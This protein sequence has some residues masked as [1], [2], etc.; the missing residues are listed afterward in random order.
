MLES[1][2]IEFKRELNKDFEKSVISFLNYPGGG[3]IYIGIADN[4]EVIGVS[5]A[6]DLQCE[7]ASRIR[8]NI[9]PITIGLFDIVLEKK[10]NKDIIRVIV[11]CGQMR[12]YYLKKYG[13]V[14]KGCFIRVGSTSQPMSEDVIDKAF[15]SRQHMSLQNTMSSRQS[16][17]H[18][19][20][21]LNYREKKF[22]ITDSFLKNLDLYQSDGKFNYLAY[23]LADDNGNSIKTAT[24]AGKDKSDVIETREYEYTCLLTSTQKVLDRLDSENRTYAKI[25]YP[26][27]IERERINTV[28]M[29]EAFINAIVHNDYSRG[30]P[31]VEIFS[32]RIVITSCGGLV[33]GL[34][35]DDFFRCRSMPRNRELMRIY[36]DM[37]FVEQI[38]SG[39]SKILKAYDKSIFDINEN[40]TEVTFMFDDSPVEEPK[41]DKKSETLNRIIELISENPKITT[42]DL[43]QHLHIPLRSIKRILKE[44]QEE[45]LI[46]REGS[47][48]FGYWIIN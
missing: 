21:M 33:D 31:L 38:G 45:G 10:Q 15:S 46:K 28:A 22:E 29:R 32:D 12:P 4:G 24:Y 48:R 14:E 18:S 9:S 2:R 19:L 17:E 41:P 7:I 43:S 35:L 40:F 36:K 42:E 1:N 30:V 39:M 8:D 34:S 37:D 20:L 16:L 26:K 6:N 25:T 47:K 27:R 23:L 5:D 11:S 44:Y 13:R 3:D